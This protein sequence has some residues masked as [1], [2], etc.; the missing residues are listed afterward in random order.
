GWHQP[1]THLELVLNKDTWNKLSDQHKAVLELATRAVTT[2]TLGRSTALQGK[3]LIDNAK[4]GVHNEVYSPELLNLF[5]KT[6]R[7]VIKQAADQDP[8]VKKVWDDYQAYFAQYRPWA[9]K[10]YLPRPKCE[11]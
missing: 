2:Y 1:V 10:A 5:H 11:K 3:A 7:K 4:H 6:W 9:C 8:M